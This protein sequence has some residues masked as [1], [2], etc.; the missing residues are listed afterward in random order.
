MALS[1][2]NSS[3][4]GVHLTMVCVAAFLTV[5]AASAETFPRT[6]REPQRGVLLVADKSLVDPN[7]SHTVVLLTDHRIVGS[8]G[9]I[10][11][12]SSSVGVVSTLP[13]LTGLE[14]SETKLR[15]G[16]PMQIR[17]VR[18]LVNSPVEIPSA[19]HL[20]EDV[21][22]VNST[23]LLRSL[24]GDKHSSASTVAIN[25]YA[26]Y[27]GWSSGQLAA[28]IARGDW[29]LIK[30]D[31]ATIFQRNPD[32]IWRDLIEKLEGTWVLME[33]TVIADNP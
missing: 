12:R 16:G 18:L 32:V 1:I 7:F 31:T 27:A 22:F 20:F 23:T 24:L 11:N 29:H 21:Y 6:V 17:S 33:N 26:G 28:E 5:G 9:L 25:Y 2:A 13:E 15:F 30:A 8:I 14:E 4:A 19:E 10:I 3:H